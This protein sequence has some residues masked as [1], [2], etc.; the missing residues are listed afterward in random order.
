MVSPFFFLT[1]KGVFMT[2]A[3]NYSEYKGT[4]KRVKRFC[5]KHRA[6]ITLAIGG[7]GLMY[8]GY[9]FGRKHGVQDTF[10]SFY[11]WAQSNNGSAKDIFH[12]Y[13]D[14][15]LDGKEMMISVTTRPFPYE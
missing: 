4:K 3:T 1:M 15:K 2:K 10:D 11:K 12:H 5:I 6:K 9:H 13:T 14:G 7:A 8:I